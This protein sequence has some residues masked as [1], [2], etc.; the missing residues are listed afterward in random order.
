MGESYYPKLLVGVPF[1]PV[2]GPRL[3]VKQGP[4]EAAVRRALADSL[5]QVRGKSGRQELGVA[6][7]ALQ[8]SG[9]GLMPRRRCCL[10]DASTAATCYCCCCCSP[11][12]YPFSH[13]L[14]LLHRWLTSWASHPSASTSPAKKSMNTWAAATA[15]CS[16]P[17]SS[18][19]GRTKTRWRRQRRWRA[20][21]SAAATARMAPV[22]TQQQRQR[23]YN[24]RRT[25]ALTRARAPSS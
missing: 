23:Q 2:T 7:Q 15:T 10:G 12:S 8:P 4:H 18:T 1:T 20:A 5:K 17:A 21:A 6:C 25:A 13:V 11:P 24:H 9:L 16:A 22:M 14:L 19:T 3:L